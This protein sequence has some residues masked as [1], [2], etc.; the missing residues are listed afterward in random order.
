[1]EGGNSWRAKSSRGAPLWPRSS[2]AFG[3][4]KK[5]PPRPFGLAVPPS[6]FPNSLSL[7]LDH[8]RSLVRPSSSLSHPGAERLLEKLVPESK[9]WLHRR[10]IVRCISRA[11]SAISHEEI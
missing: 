7:S 2:Q 11:C 5:R 1:M 4:S 9:H 10:V 3:V 8:Y 6:Q